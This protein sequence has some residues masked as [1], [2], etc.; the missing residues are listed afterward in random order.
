[1]SVIVQ[2]FGGTSVSK[3][4][5][6]IRCLGHVQNELENGHKVVVVISA[7]GRKGDPYATDTLLSLLG[8]HRHGLSNKDL[9]LFL[10]TGELISASVFSNLLHEHGIANTILTGGQAGIITN[11]QYNDAKITALHPQKLEHALRTHDVVVVPGFQGITSDGET[12]TLGRG[13]SDTTATAIGVS[14]R[15]DFVD[16]F[17][18]VEG[19]M[20][21]DPRIVSHAK[22]L[23][24]AG[25][26]EI[27]NFAYLGAK[28]I[29]PR[30]VEIAM[31]ENI[32]IRV[33]STFSEHTGT[34]ITNMTELNS[35]PSEKRPV[36]GITQ[37]SGLIHLS[38]PKSRFENVYQTFS[39]EGIS[40]DF[41]Q[42]NT[43]SASFTIPTSLKEQTI[44]ILSSTDWR[45]TV[46]EG[47]A[48]I[49]IVGSGMHGA[50]GVMSRALGV[51]YEHEIDVHQ[52]AD[53]HTTIWFLV[54]EKQMNEAV[55]L[56]HDTF[57]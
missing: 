20:T 39:E 34:L 27:C 22:V 3:E 40:I 53:S 52:T 33:R 35:N 41:I 54:K 14:L 19:I 47:M 10:S 15:A 2:K 11:N 45:P 31:H 7:M 48:K 30:A 5:S 32:P 55:C 37:T 18:D 8:G 24:K 50:P 12:T 17:T 28:V 25:Y 13:G 16:I 42:T 38:I 36:I 23:D 51:L 4:E 44:N 56:L 46:T 6:R 21:A 1:M 49:A 9:D 26:N 43:D 57:I 29:H